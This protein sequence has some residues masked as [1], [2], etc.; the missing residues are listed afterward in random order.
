MAEKIAVKNRSIRHRQY[1][2]YKTEIYAGGR[3]CIVDG[4][5]TI[6]SIYNKSDYC[7][8][9][10]I[11]GLYLDFVPRKDSQ[12]VRTIISDGHELVVYGTSKLGPAPRE[13]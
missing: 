12:P 2:T 1:S 13:E 5:K 10:K 7:G 6:L 4:C 11:R 3:I 9:C 8:S